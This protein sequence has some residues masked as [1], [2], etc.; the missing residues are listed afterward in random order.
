MWAQV[1][2]AA[3]TNGS[4]TR[5]L[6]LE[7]AAPDQRGPKSLRYAAVV[8]DGVL[9]KLVSARCFWADCFSPARRPCY[10]GSRSRILALH[11]W[12]GVPRQWAGQ[13][14]ERR[15]LHGVL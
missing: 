2:V 9:L 4:W 14:Q 7:Q 12:H 13:A 1:K 3:D 15:C 5:Y 10:M 11:C 6:G 8:D